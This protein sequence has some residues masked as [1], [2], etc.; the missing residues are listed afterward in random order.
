MGNMKVQFDPF[1]HDTHD[2]PYPIYRALRDEARIH[3]R[4]HW[5]GE[6]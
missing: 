6:V 3:G 5:C 4:V 2:N 1:D